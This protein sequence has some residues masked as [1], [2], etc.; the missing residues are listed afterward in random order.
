[1]LVR[2]RWVELQ[3]RHFCDMAS[4]YI[5]EQAMSD[6]AGA[7]I[8]TLDKLYAAIFDGILK[9]NPVAYSV[10]AQT[11]RLMLCLHETTSP[12]TLLA[13]ASITRDGS[14]NSLELS[15]L[16]RICSHL[17]VLDDELD[18]IRFAHASVQ[19]YLSRLPE[20]SMVNANGAA[21]WSCLIRCI[22]SPLPELTHGV[23]PSRDFDVYAAMYWPLH[24]NAASEHDRSSYLGNALR[25]FM[26]SDQEF[27]APFSS[28]I[29]TVDEIAKML[30]RPHTR[31]SDLIAIKSENAT[32][33]FTACLYGLEFA[34]ETLS[35]MP[36]FDVNQKN[37]CGHTGLYL[38][39]A[40]GQIHVVDGLLKLGADITI[41]GGRNTTPLQA[42]C[43]NGHGE[44]AQLIIDFPSR[45]PPSW[46]DHFGYT[47]SIT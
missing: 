23:Q 13:A 47:S 19:E 11:F 36:S 44:I 21:A 6:P 37:A 4:I 29:D 28:W 7:S 35:G 9:I 26:F 30:L 40:T 34:V 22:D 5:I 10:A 16:L 25:E 39:S 1:M 41:E 17:V 42:A 31:I 33:F 45:S 46:N 15:D 24:Y 3:L 8:R 38:A 18:T 27:M 20:F 2:F 12:A 43:A 32:P 14:Q